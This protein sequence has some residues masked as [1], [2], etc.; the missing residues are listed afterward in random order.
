MAKFN[1]TLAREYYVTHEDAS[2]SKISEKFG[3]SEQAIQMYQKRMDEN[4]PDLRRQALAK[5][6]EMLPEISGNTIARFQAEKLSVGKYL[7]SEGIKGIKANPPKSAFVAN[8]LVESG[9]KLS[10]QAMGLDKPDVQVNV[11]IMTI[12]QF[13]VEMQKRKEARGTVTDAVIAPDANG[14]S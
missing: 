9:Y 7:V 11:G 12:D 8:L 6:K 4:W 3:M 5:A 10:T 14:T 2:Y 13:V 1:F